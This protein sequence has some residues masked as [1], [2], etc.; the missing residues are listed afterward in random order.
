M[1]SDSSTFSDV[2]GWVYDNVWGVPLGIGVVILAA[3]MAGMDARH[4]ARQHRDGEQPP[5]H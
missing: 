3:V 1:S 2:M 4:R 5:T